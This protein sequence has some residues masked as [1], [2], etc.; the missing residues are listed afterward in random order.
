MCRKW[1]SIQFVF[2]NTYLVHKT[3]ENFALVNETLI[4]WKSNLHGGVP[5][6]CDLFSLVIWHLTACLFI[7][8]WHNFCNK[9]AAYTS[10]L[11]NFFV[12]YVGKY[13]LGNWLVSIKGKYS[14]K[15]FRLSFDGGGVT[16]W[17][18]GLHPNWGVP[19]RAW[20]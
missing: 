13:I 3:Q 11:L 8:Q 4:Q 5:L 14:L 15:V 9:A 16:W 17:G 2:V 20:M 10:I 1:T 7:F 6:C 19:S 18:L 12:F